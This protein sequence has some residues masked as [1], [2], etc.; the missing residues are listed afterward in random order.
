MAQRVFSYGTL[1]LPAV[2]EA[3]LGRQVATVSDS[4]PGWRLER[5][6]IT[7]AKVIATSGSDSHPILRRASAGET[8]DGA[9]LIIDDDELAAL[10]AYEVPDYVR[11]EVTLASGVR[12][13]VYVAAD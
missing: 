1:Q 7:D 8:V 12:V 9:Y 4:L 10:D 3:L 5:V 11:I 2:Q 6:T 13:W